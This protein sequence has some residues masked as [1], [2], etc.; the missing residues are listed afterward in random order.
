[1]H[2]PTLRTFAARTDPTVDAEFQAQAPP[3]PDRA[4]SPGALASA[5]RAPALLIATTVLAALLALAVTAF[6]HPDR[7]AP[8]ATARLDR[9]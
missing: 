6:A 7:L 3:R 8:N 1:M 4:R 5:L 2:D 9:G